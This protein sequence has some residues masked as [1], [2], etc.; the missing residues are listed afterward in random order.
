MCP[1][2]APQVLGCLCLAAHLDYLFLPCP[3]P[4]TDQ[5]IPDL[6][7]SPEQA[8]SAQASQPRSEASRATG[9]WLQ[10]LPYL[11]SASRPTQQWVWSRPHKPEALL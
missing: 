5:G 8:L 2:E 6:R 11:H 1:R 9:A 10:A 7:V 4:H 3:H